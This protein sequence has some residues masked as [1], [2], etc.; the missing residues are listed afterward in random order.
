MLRP[1]LFLFL[2]AFFLPFI[3]VIVFLGYG[4]S[5]CISAFFV[6]LIIFGLIIFL[7]PALCHPQGQE[8]GAQVAFSGTAGDRARAS[9]SSSS[10]TWGRTFSTK[11]M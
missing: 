8:K 7:L 5:P 2:L 3:L 6:V 1:S 9:S 4:Y 11:E 10:S